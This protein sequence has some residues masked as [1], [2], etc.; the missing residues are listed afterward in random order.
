MVSPASVPG[1]SGTVGNRCGTSNAWIAI[2]SRCPGAR[3]AV[4]GKTST[5]TGAT[6]PFASDFFDAYVNGW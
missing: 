6:W 2:R 5:S 1:R 3:C 4:V